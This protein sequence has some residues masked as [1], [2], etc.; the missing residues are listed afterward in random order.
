[1]TDTVKIG[2]DGGCIGL[3]SP[4]GRSYPMRDGVAEVPRDEARKFLASTDS[5][6][7]HRP[8]GLGWSRRREAAWERVFGGASD[9]EEESCF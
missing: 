8:V 1:M 9:T 4:S 7:I 2:A 5:L 3:D 6:H